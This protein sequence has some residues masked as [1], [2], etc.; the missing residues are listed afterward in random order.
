VEQ[1]GFELQLPLLEQE[2]E[3]KKKLWIALLVIFGVFLAG[4]M[5]GAIL[6]IF[7]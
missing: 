2:P 1:P 5:I 4:M 6:G 3:V 7:V